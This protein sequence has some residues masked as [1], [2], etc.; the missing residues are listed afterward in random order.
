LYKLVKQVQKTISAAKSS[1]ATKANLE[2]SLKAGSFLGGMLP[3]NI[4]SAMAAFA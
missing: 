4:G 3:V 2:V 1:T